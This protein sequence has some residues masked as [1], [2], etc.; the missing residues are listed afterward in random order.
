MWVEVIDENRFIDILSQ[1]A[2]KDN[3]IDRLIQMKYSVV[4]KAVIAK[5]FA[6]TVKEKSGQEFALSASVAKGQLQMNGGGNSASSIDEVI[7]R[8]SS[9]PVVL[10]VDFFDS[11]FL[12]KNRA[13]LVAPVFKAAGETKVSVRASDQSGELWQTENA[14]PFGAPVRI[15]RGGGGKG[16]PNCEG[17]I[18]SSAEFYSYVVSAPK[19]NLEAQAFEF[20]TNGVIFGGVSTSGGGLFQ[21]CRQDPGEVTAEVSFDNRIRTTVRSDSATTLQVALNNVPVTSVDVID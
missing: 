1:A 20:T 3:C 9:T 16:S 6:I 11:D 2:I 10:G 8:S 13:K 14:A 21:G 19:E 12:S 4:S 17:A 7:K 18:P 15:N 5:G